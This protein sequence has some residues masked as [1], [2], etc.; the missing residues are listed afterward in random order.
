M[1]KPAKTWT[2]CLPARLIPRSRP[3]PPLTV[4]L[5]EESRAPSS[6]QNPARPEEGRYYG[7]ALDNPKRDDRLC[8]GCECRR[9]FRPMHNSARAW[10]SCF[11][12]DWHGRIVGF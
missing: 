4:E 9:N 10:E 1:L 2:L 5:F 11:A 7:L 8:A 6:D 3:V 12:L